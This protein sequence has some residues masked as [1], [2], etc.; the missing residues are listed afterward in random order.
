MQG[1]KNQYST[2]KLGKLAV[3]NLTN[4]SFHKNRKY[5]TNKPVSAAIIRYVL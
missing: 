3:R 5:A 4:N 1:G 2:G